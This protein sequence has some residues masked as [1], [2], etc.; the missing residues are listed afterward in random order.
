MR[1][2]AHP[3]GNEPPRGLEPPPGEKLPREA[4]M[5]VQTNIQRPNEQAYHCPE[6]NFMLLQQR[7]HFRFCPLLRE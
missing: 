3:V 6:G 1:L 4:I 7:D 2:I 5:G